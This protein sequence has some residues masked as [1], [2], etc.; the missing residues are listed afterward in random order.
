MKFQGEI[1][2]KTN[3]NTIPIFTVFKKDWDKYYR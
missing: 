3:E 1:K 2:S